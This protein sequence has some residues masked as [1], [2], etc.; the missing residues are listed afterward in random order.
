VASR[1]V[2]R[3]S[4]DLRDE[5]RDLV[6]LELRQRLAEIEAAGQTEPVDGPSAVLREVDLVDVRLKQCVLVVPELECNGHEGFADLSPERPFGGQKV[7]AH[8]LLCQRAAALL[9]LSCSHVGDECAGDCANVD[10][11]VIFEAPVFD[12]DQRLLQKLGR[13]AGR[14][15]DSIF[16]VCRKD[17][18]DQHRIEL[19]KAQDLP[20]LPGDPI[21]AVC[22]EVHLCNLRRTHLIA[23][24]ERARPELDLIRLQSIRAAGR[25]CVV[26]TVPQPLE[27]DDEILSAH[28]TTGIELER[29]GKDLCGDVPAACVEFACDLPTDEHAVDDRSHGED[30]ERLDDQPAYGAFGFSHDADSTLISSASRFTTDVMYH[31]G[32]FVR[33][34]W[35]T[36][37]R[38]TRFVLFTA[39]SL[40]LL[41]LGVVV[42]Q[43]VRPNKPGLTALDYYEIEQLMYRYAHAIDTC[44]ND[45]YNYADVFTDDGTFVDYFSEEGFS[46]QGLVR[47]VGRQALANISGGGERGCENVGWKDWSHLMI[48]PVITPTPEG[49][50]G[51]VYLV[52]IGEQGPDHA[53]RFGGYEDEFVRTPDGWRIKRRTHVRNKAWSH[54]LLQSVDLN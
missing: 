20:G 18:A 8:E 15:Y 47:A 36:K 12:R 51:R 44:A 10:A 54:P 49:A 17:A 24:C 38:S 1:V 42:A 52:V 45:G 7:A 48:N 30:G 6:Q 41:G 40:F 28:S 27:L 3:R 43:Q 22:G 50:T 37:M 26:A 19:E 34:L 11:D 39:G 53:Q 32:Q 23:A 9:N 4:S 35:G 29:C 21:D 25:E 14:Q 33:Q 2:K 16:T 46:H 31:R 13:L 5:E